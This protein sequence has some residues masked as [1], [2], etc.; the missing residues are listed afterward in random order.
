M[1]TQSAVF[2]FALPED[3]DT[4]QILIKSSTTKDGVFS[5]DATVS[6]EYGETTHEFDSLNDTKWYKIQFNN[7]TDGESGPESEPVYGGDFDKG[8]P[9]LAISTL[10]DGANYA[11]NQDVYDYSTLTTA[12]VTNSRVS[13][14][15]RRARAV[16]D[17]RTA[18]LDL[19][20][21]TRT[22]DTEPARKKYN[23]VLRIIKEA[24]INL[25][26]GNIYKGLSDDILMR[27]VRDTL[28]GTDT[29]FEAVAIGATR[30]SEG[31]GLSNV[32]HVTQLQLLGKDYFSEGNRLLEQIQPPSIRMHAQQNFRTFPLFRFPFNGF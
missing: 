28:G 31:G 23:A 16:V 4:D 21:F 12:D 19:S 29:G 3:T 25:A 10:S 24:E 9:F 26:L 18:E 27:D 30:L 2:T 11:S 15:L 1:A 17:L 22:F 6:Y 32:D 13:Q 20:R 5:T 8:K 14:A 7:S